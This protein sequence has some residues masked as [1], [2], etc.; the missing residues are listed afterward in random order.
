MEKGKK[1]KTLALI[2][3]EKYVTKTFTGEKENGQMKGMVSMRMLILSYTIQ[4]VIP[5][6]CTKF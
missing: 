4:E 1:L 2:G 5:N 3:P 6:V